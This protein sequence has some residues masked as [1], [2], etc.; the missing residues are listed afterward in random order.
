MKQSDSREWLET[1]QVCSS[2][3]QRQIINALAT[4]DRPLRPTEVLRRLADD[5][6]PRSTS[7]FY[8]HL[9][10]LLR[11][12]LLRSTELSP[13]LAFYALTETGRAL[14]AQLKA[15]DEATASLTS[16]TALKT[17]GS[18]F[19]SHSHADNE[20]VKRLAGDLSRHG[21]RV[22]LD[23][24][25]M[26]VGDSLIQKI[27]KAIAETDFVGVVLS[28]SSVKSRWVRKEV[29]IAMTREISGKYVK[30]LPFVLESCRIP[31][32]LKDKIYADFRDPRHY[33]SELAR[34]VARIASRPSPRKPSAPEGPPQV[35]VST[36]V[37]VPHYDALEWATNTDLDELQR[38]PNE[39]AVMSF[40]RQRDTNTLLTLLDDAIERLSLIH[41]Y[42][43][44][45]ASKNLL[46]AMKLAPLS[47]DNETD[48]RQIFRVL[49]TYVANPEKPLIG[50]EYFY[51]AILECLDDLTVKE[52]VL[53]RGF[54]EDYVLDLKNATTFE[55][56]KVRA[57][58]IALFANKLTTRQKLELV[59]AI[60][61]Q[62]QVLESFGAQSALRSVI[63]TIRNDIPG[64][65]VKTLREH[66][67]VS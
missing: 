13:R 53:K 38:L 39:E 12:G 7:R 27:S 47:R 63:E 43:Q 52:Y 11:L 33:Q 6:R 61:T 24:A 46:R 40:L 26:L 67:F 49:H 20:F 50:I 22:W 45:E 2:A 54:L 51:A 65:H 31:S 1:L 35:A 4:A 9:A 5:G 60:V 57:K 23:E 37:Q 34:I 48:K 8:Y 66:H 17:D 32:Y 59:S 64:E 44:I 55:D 14:F 25:E 18:L 58:V 19:L 15:D 3:T 36:R 28:K 30:V 29:D 21:I 62:N 41:D 10:K 42:K 16:G 56:A